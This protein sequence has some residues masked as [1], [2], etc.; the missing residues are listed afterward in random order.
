VKAN[1][2]GNHL[3]SLRLSVESSLKRLRTS[4]LDILY[5]HWWDYN[6]SVEEVM[7]GLHNL[8][9]QGKVLYL[10]SPISMHLHSLRH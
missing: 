6:T 10:V 8:V 7:D 3:K 4:Y 2:T 5:V 9:V 1:F